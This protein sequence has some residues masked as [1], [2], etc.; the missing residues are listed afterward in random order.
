MFWIQFFIKYVFCK[1]FLPVWFVFSV[2]DIVFQKTVK[3]SSEKKFLVLMKFILSII[4][5]TDCAFDIISKKPS[6]Y[7]RTSRFSPMLSSMSF[8]A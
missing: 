6:P 4:S 8:I 1:Y 7:P 5:F 3:D 2:P